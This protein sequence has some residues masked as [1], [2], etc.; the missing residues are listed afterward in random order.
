MDTVDTILLAFRTFVQ[1][2][3]SHDPSFYRIQSPR[4]RR[5]CPYPKFFISVTIFADNLYH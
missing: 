3:Q 4:N 2:I 5:P 1:Y